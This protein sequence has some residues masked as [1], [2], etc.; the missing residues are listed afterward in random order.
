MGSPAA[1]ITDP[2]EG[3][4]DVP[5]AAP[6]TAPA[7]SA[8]DT[9]SG[10][11]DVPEDK[12]KPQE[13]SALGFG[14]NVLSSTGHLLNNVVKSII[15]YDAT[16][17]NDIIPLKRAT[18][19][20]VDLVYGTG[21][22]AARHLGSNLPLDQSDQTLQNFRDYI[23]NRY[24]SVDRFKD[25]LYHDPAG[26]AADLST[27]LTGGESVAEAL[28][29]MGGV[30][31]VLGKGA[32]ITNPMYLPSKIA[33]GTI[34]ALKT[35]PPPVETPPVERRRTRPSIP[36]RRASRERRSIPARGRSGRRRAVATSPRRHAPASIPR[37]QPLAE[38]RGSSIPLRAHSRCRGAATNPRR[39]NA[40]ASQRRCRTPSSVSGRSGESNPRSPAWR[41]RSSRRSAP[42]PEQPQP[43][44]P[45]RRAAPPKPP[46]L[47]KDVA[48]A[49][50]LANCPGI[51]GGGPGGWVL[52]LTGEPST[53]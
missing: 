52:A 43:R 18:D 50:L 33:S 45:R 24:G 14:A 11:I 36:R 29:G 6:T 25:T 51:T 9:N 23:G 2:N 3:W 13:K 40:E 35:K 42:P 10:W 16:N 19:T 39:R 28:P 15:P 4:V 26:V 44:E 48:G 7:A 47:P 17:L 37:R 21:R 12:P 38:T 20:L 32:E 53:Y 30:A 22:L 8:Q 41:P 1:P 34:S 5:A 31:K 49:A 27:V 46:P